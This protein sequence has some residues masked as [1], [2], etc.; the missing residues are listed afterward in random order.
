MNGYKR[1][2]ILIL[3]SSFLL[4]GLAFRH[5]LAA[6]ERILVFGRVYDDPV[7]SVK[8]RQQFVD[9]MAKKLAP[10]GINGGT[11]L[12]LDKMH[13]LAQA[14]KDGKVDLFHDSVVPTM[15]LSRWSGSVPILR[16]WKYGEADYSGIIVV[17]KSSG[18][19]T[20]ADLKGKVIGFDEPHST[21]AS[22]LP[23][24][25]L[26]EH[27]LKLV[28]IKS[29]GVVNPDTVGY[30]YGEDGSSANRLITGRVDA[31]A[32]I[33]REIERLQPDVRET[34]KIIGRTISVPRQIISVRKDL[35]PKIVKAL[36]EILIN[37]DKN[38][39]G[40]AALKSQQN[41][42]KFDEIPPGSLEHLKYIERYVFS[43]L[44]GQVDSW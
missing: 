30:V 18:I 2:S 14:L 42:T 17:K 25:L 22:V 26:E 28:E 4:L 19:D 12:V 10:L 5:P 9:Y 44:R 39:E 41:T 15:V 43:T 21:S 23:R 37:M 29:P 27:K 34:L 32:S 20:L 7:R 11:I 3:L 38:P 6:E 24:M 35:D 31:A 33:D 36:K 1:L 16:Q 8:D 40:Q 13:L